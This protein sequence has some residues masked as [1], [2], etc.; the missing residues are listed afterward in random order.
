MVIM[1]MPRKHSKSKAVAPDAGSEKGGKEQELV[2]E[3]EKE[4]GKGKGKSAEVPA[5]VST[6]LVYITHR[7]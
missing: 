3:K 2:K 5:K 7:H 6:S 4:K 1:P